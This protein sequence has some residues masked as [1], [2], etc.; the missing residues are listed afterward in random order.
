LGESESALLFDGDL[1][2]TLIRDPTVPGVFRKTKDP[3][4]KGGLYDAGI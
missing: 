2:A 3:F 4:G 1:D